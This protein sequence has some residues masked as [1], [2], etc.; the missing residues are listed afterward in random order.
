LQRLR[1]VR[2]YNEWVWG[3]LAP[4]VGDRVLEIG[5][6]VGNFTQFLRNRT[7]VVATDNNEQYLQLVRNTFEHSDNIHVQRIDWEHPDIA[8]LKAHR[9]DT[10]VCLNALEHIENDD[11]A[12]ATFSQL[13][14]PGG[15]LVLQVP[16]MRRLYGEIDR[17]I[18]HFRRYE[19]DELVAK[20]TAHG[21]DPVE[22]IS[23]NLPGVLAWYLNS[24]LLRRRTVPGLQARLVNWIVPW[25]RLERHWEPRR[26]M[27]L[28]AVGRKVRQV[29]EAAT[30]FAIADTTHVPPG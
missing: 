21:F 25:L 24:V 16:A 2:R 17:A 28:I 8:A 1:H 3:Q 29:D 15:Q 11:G 19:R 9:F 5:C 13:L 12:L 7:A 30:P 14:A 26:G 10:I 6:G 20:L 4:H 23:F 27:A 22:V 18:G